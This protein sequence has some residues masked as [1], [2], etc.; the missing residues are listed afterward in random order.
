MNL[1]NQKRTGLQNLLTNNWILSS[2]KP[3]IDFSEISKMLYGDEKFIKEFSEA[4]VISFSE[5]Q[6]NYIQF[7]LQRDE[8]NFRKAG[9]KI[10]PVAQMLNLDQI[11]KEYEHGKTLLWEEKMDEEL[12]ASAQRIET[13]C[14]EVIAELNEK[15]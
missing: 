10:K 11:L 6:E 7:L 4:A 1:A 9:H 2:K 13:I 12:K 8:E 15:T 14:N 5:F 3:L